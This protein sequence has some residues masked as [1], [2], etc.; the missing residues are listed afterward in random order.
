[1]ALTHL[2]GVPYGP[3]PHSAKPEFASNLTWPPW[4]VVIH[5]TANDATAK[6]ECQY[7]AT[8]T[9]PRRKW[10]SAHF[11][12]DSRG[13]LGGVPMNL[14][15]WAAFSYANSH[16]W[17]IEMCGYNVGRPG[18]VP[19][20][21]IATTAALTRRLCDLIG[22]PKVHLGPTELAA[23]RHG[24]TGHWDITRGLNVGDHDD[25]G[26]AFD[27]PA[28][29]AMVNEEEDMT[30]EQ[31]RQL[32]NVDRLVTAL[33]LDADQVTELR[34]FPGDPT[35]VAHPL[36]IA[37]RVR[38]LEATAAGNETRDKATLAAIEA[39]TEQIRA[40]GGNADATTVLNRIDAAAAETVRLVEELRTD[41]ATARDLLAKVEADRLEL[42]AK[43]AA[44]TR[45]ETE[46]AVVT[47]APQD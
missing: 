16:G 28:F 38:A 27:W 19:P 13:V 8:R 11:Y 3:P 24:I 17:H 14:R 30:P 22:I 45:S 40:G 15:A 9:D 41:L 7:A 26:P 23:G 12:V 20:A 32:F 31:S 44:A 42:Q 43:L 10:T 39:L 36:R 25:P 18:A 33:L 2:P 1:M 37:Q 29:I 21:T 5:A 35:P 6:E 4:L 34:E 47:G 46:V